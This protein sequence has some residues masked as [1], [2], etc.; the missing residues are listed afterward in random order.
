M[1]AEAFKKNG[2]VPDVVSSAPEKVVKVSFDSGVEVYLICIFEN[3]LSPFLL[4]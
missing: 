4:G 1:A 2:V 3:T